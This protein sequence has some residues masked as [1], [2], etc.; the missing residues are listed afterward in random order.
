MYTNTKIQIDE[1][2]IREPENINILLM[3]HHKR[4]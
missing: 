4:N 3:L 1:Q 2:A